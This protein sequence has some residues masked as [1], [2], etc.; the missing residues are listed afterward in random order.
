MIRRP[1]RSTLFPYTTLFRSL[2][3]GGD[4][5]LHDRLEQGGGGLLHRLLESQGTGDFEGDVGRV[6]VVVRTVV[7]HDTEIDHGVASEKPLHAGVLD[8]LLDGRDEILRAGAPEDVVLEFEAGAA[9]Q[10]L[11]ADPAGARP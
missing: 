2:S 5:D 6:D 3:R 7:Q 4:F 1:P 8:S 11:E 9:R 10:R